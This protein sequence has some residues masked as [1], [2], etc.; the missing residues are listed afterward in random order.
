MIRAKAVLLLTACVSMVVGSMDTGNSSSAVGDLNPAFVFK[1][2]DCTQELSGKPLFGAIQGMTVGYQFKLIAHT[3]ID[4]LGYW[5]CD[6]KKRCAQDWS[7]S[8]GM[9]DDHGN[10]VIP[11]TTVTS[12]NPIS[13]QFHWHK[14]DKP[15]QVRA[16]VYRIGG[17]TIAENGYLVPVQIQQP[18]YVPEFEYV[19]SARARQWDGLSFP[20]LLE[21]DTQL[22]EYGNNAFGLVSFGVNVRKTEFG[23]LM[24]LL[25]E[26]ELPVCLSPTSLK[27][28]PP[29]E[30]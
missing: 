25:P 4:A 20:D 9:W 10:V 12:E 24:P 21:G 27:V 22:H 16:G 8:V 17:K 13:S 3:T 1:R 14:L 11:E 23:R 18:Q 15:V 28:C 2:A 19:S 6:D 5:S 30:N 7:A 29:D 26:P